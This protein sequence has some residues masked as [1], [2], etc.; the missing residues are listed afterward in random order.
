MTR[1]IAVISLGCPKNL[2][3][4][5]GMV[6]DFLSRD[7]ELVVDPADADVVLVNTCGFLAAARDESVGA[8]KEVA[9]LKHEG[10]KAL[11]VTGCMVGHYGDRIRSEVPE[12]DRLVDFGDYARLGEMVEEILP[13]T[14]GASFTVPGRYVQA[15]LTPAHFAYLKISEGCNHTCSFC[16]IPKIRGRMRSFGL[17][18]LVGRARRL[19]GIGARE[20]N[21]VAQDSTMYGVDLYGEMRIVELLRRLADVEGLS[22]LRLL[23]A[24]PTEVDEALIELLAEAPGALLP[25]LDV[26]LQHSSGRML[27]LMNRKSSESRVEEM[28]TA[29]RGAHRPITIRTTMIVGF[30]GETDEDFEHLLDFV[31]RHRID[32]LGAFIWSPEEGSG[33][34][35]LPDHVDPDVKQDRHDRLMRLQATIAAE[36][37]AE[38]LGE[39]LEVLVESPATV[40]QPA[41]GRS[42]HDAPEIDGTVHLSGPEV[43]PGELVQARV[44]AARGYDLDAVVLV[45]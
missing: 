30:P 25:Y 19:V 29:L 35:S 44:T 14:A 21:V 39:T 3:D 9:K 11:F 13:R 33:A 2:V 20:I 10:L 8:L 4:S 37:S 17:E 24:Y 43:A 34:M 16:V 41:R 18:D 22:W 36:V 27:E 26:P 15:R 6:S 38:R 12:V 1:R 42:V 32:R 31:G 7:L 45:H 5:E 23:Y 40:D 28:M